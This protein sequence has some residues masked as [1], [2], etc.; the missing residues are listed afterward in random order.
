MASLN[1]IQSQVHSYV[2]IEAPSVRR[3]R[4]IYPDHGKHEQDLRFQQLQHTGRRTV[5]FWSLLDFY[6]KP[7]C[8]SEVGYVLLMVSRFPTNHPISTWICGFIHW[9]SI[10]FNLSQ[11]HF[12]LSPTPRKEIISLKFLWVRENTEISVQWSWKLRDAKLYMNTKFAPHRNPQKHW[13]W[14][15]LLL[16]KCGKKVMLPCFT[17]CILKHTVSPNFNSRTPRQGN[18]LGLTAGCGLC[19][20]IAIAGGGQTHSLVSYQVSALPDPKRTSVKESYW[21]FVLPVNQ[22]QTATH[23]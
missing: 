1:H 3:Q 18:K 8:F 6:A 2:P 22:N 11:P 14:L 17:S 13:R 15:L 4:T 21:F 5:K 20:I 9:P 12:P 23:R 7:N 16:G 19:F 10:L